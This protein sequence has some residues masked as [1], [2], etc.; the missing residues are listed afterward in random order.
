MTQI[1]QKLGKE[2]NNA[3]SIK[4]LESRVDKIKV[5]L[6]I[7]IDNQK[8]Q[9]QLFQQ[10]LNTTEPVQTLMKTKRGDICNSG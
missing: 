10:L 5:Q 2:D 3:K 6:A 7:M 9:T 4:G 8:L 1:Q